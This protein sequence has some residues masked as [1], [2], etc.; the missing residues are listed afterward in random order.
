MKTASLSELEEILGSLASDYDVRVPVAAYDGTRILGAPAEGPL[1]LLGGAVPKKITSVFFPQC[2]RA[3]RYDQGTVQVQEKPAKPLLVV[4]F[5]AEDLDCLDFIDRFFSAEFRDDIYFNKRDG[6]VL[7]AVSG[8]C[9]EGGEFLKIAGGKCDLE[10]I[11]DGERFLVVPYSAVGKELCERLGTPGSDSSLEALRRESE[12]QG[13]EDEETLRAA[14]E[15]ILADKVPDA[16]WDEIGKS[17]I[18][19]TSCNYAC[20]T[21]TCFDVYDRG[22][23]KK[24]ER[25]RI[26]DSCMLD[27]FMR[28]ASGHNP[29]GT[30]GLRTRRRIH[31]KLAA[32]K[33]R[34]GEITCY[35]C[36]RC[37]EVCPTGIGIKAVSR[38]IVTRF[39]E[40][41]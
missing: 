14:S 8:K 18:A 22:D 28:E 38:E 19:C 9:G 35:L 6:A 31:H 16:F 23:R 33:N 41:A 39:G 36:G 1:T 29:M 27:G 17:C 5:T 30:E 32:D 40:G 37:D 12:F 15:I 20:P 26:W 21:C 24:G 3:F 2:E 11:Y 7:V 4:G 13:T 34:W 25:H 10:L